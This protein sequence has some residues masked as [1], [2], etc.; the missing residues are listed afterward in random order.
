MSQ[1]EAGYIEEHGKWKNH[2]GGSLT[3]LLT[4]PHYADMLEE[5]ACKSGEEEVL[6]RPQSGL[7][8]SRV[9]W[10]K[11]MMKWVEEEQAWSDDSDGEGLGNAMYGRHRSKWL[12]R[13][14][15]LLFGGRK[16]VD[17]DE[18][19]RRVHRREAYT[20]EAHLME[21]QADEEA[22]EDR[23]PDDGELEGSGDDFN[24]WVRLTK[25]D[26]LG[27]SLNN[28]LDITLN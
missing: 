11:E 17:V 2:D 14:L 8:K 1:T 16:E 9:G 22:D 27:R 4:V 28:P 12:P 20:E 25:L 7:V 21:L 23:L 15:E 13:S 3:Q 6:S 18:Q 24:G 10:R 19:L 26:I 5:E